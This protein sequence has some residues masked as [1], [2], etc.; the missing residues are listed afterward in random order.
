MI[1]KKSIDQVLQIAK[2]ED[3]INDFVNLK[4]RGA[5]LL[6]LCPFHN[7]KTPSFNVSPSK[8]IY[9]CFGCGKAG[10]P[11]QFVIEHEKLS[12][13]EAIRYLAKKYNIPLDEI[14]DSK[15][16]EQYQEEL[17]HE[18][19]SLI[20]EYAAKL[21]IEALY[22][23][24]KG[25]TIALSY[26]KERGFLD[27][28]I[29]AFQL[30]YA[31]DQKDFLVAQL[32]EKGFNSNYIE[33]IGLSNKNG[34]DF[35]TNR[36]IFPIHSLVGKVIAFSGR[37]LSQHDFGPKYIN[38]KETPLYFKSK[39]LYGMHLAKQH[40]RAKD[41]CLLVEGYTDVISMYQAGIQNVVASSGT[42][43]TEDQIRLV[44]RFTL[45]IKILYD[46]DPAGLKA[47]LRALDMIVEEGLNV[48][49]V[50]LP[51]P[52]D[53][54]SF[55]KKHG[56]N[57]VETYLKEKSV[58]F[59]L[60]KAGLIK[61]ES[62]ND[63]IKKSNGISDILRTI[64]LIPDAIKRST[65]IQ[66]CSHELE[67]SEQI[68]V[69]ELNKIIKQNLVNKRAKTVQQAFKEREE[70]DQES[71]TDFTQT[72]PGPAGKEEDEYQERSL[73]RV[74]ILYGHEYINE[75]MTVAQYINEN[76]EGLMDDFDNKLYERIL[77]EYIHLLSENQTVDTDYFITHS[78]QEIRNLAIELIQ[79][80]YSYSHNWSD[81]WEMELQTQKPPDQNYARDSYQSVL[82]FKLRKVQKMIRENKKELD[83]PDAT[84]HDHLVA[85]KTQHDLLQSRNIIAELLGMRVIA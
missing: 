85:L 71:S 14:T 41:E 60:F 45:N 51:E 83:N 42:S 25:K 82:R 39:V 73:I 24:T 5:N 81:R 58:D 79:L 66:A 7:E 16:S 72:H 77:K 57:Y 35:F 76:M 49:I 27:T 61:K 33:E 59:V 8:N 47:T 48:R 38:S 29:K 62:Q 50:L 75:N 55:V 6:G 32:I 2:V 54:D 36:V 10:G 12:Y 15:S 9:K 22:N 3:V 44:K 34:H 31:P 67:V 19:Y 26:F 69:G 13:P 63:P 84:E 53:P 52:E 37:K 4:K 20:N 17:K 68:L 43:L 46:G 28:T 1:S 64:A 65:Y 80:P 23:H 70:N 18:A 40:I 21:Y 56:S 30:G 74:L 11:L 78:N